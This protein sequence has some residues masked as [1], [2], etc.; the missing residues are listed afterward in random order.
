[1]TLTCPIA[2]QEGAA[3]GEHRIRIVTTKADGPPPEAI[4]AARK[5]LEAEE[6]KGGGSIENVTDEKVLAYLSDTQ[7]MSTQRERL[8]ARYNTNS[9]LT[10]TVPPEGTA[11]ADFQLVSQ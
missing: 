2:Q 11:A 9:E 1:Y 4:E 5:R 3:V 10:F 7:P 8:P 6:L